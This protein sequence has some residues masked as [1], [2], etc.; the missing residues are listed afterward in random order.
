MIEAGSFLSKDDPELVDIALRCIE[1][2]GVTLYGDTAITGIAPHGHGVAV[3]IA[4]NEGERVLTGSHL[5]VAAGRAPN[6]EDLG[7]EAAEI[8]HDRRG[9]RV[10]ASLRSS[11]RRVYAIG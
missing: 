6:I 3:T 9:I 1:D 11:N 7:L 5:L 4:E 10:N 8:A 2:E